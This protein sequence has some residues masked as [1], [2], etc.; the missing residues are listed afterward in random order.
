[1]FSFF[2]K[3]KTQDKFPFHLLETDMHS[4]ILPGLD[5]GS[6]DPETSLILIKGLQ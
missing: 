1:M 3:K 4:H 2:K 6:P 5:D